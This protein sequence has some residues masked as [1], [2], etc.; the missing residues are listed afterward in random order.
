VPESPQQ[1][2][3]RMLAHSHGKDGLK[4]QAAS[5]AKLSRLIRNVPPAK[6]RKRPAPGKWSV[7]EICA[8]LADTEFAIGFRLRSILGTPGCAISAFN[9][10]A[11]ASAMDYSRRKIRESIEDFRAVR[12]AN[13]DLLN[14]IR[15]EQW[16]DY[17]IH[18]ERGQ[19]TIEHIVNLIA[20]HDLNHIAQIEA[21]LK[22]AKK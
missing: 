17:G 5:A 8:H 4:I 20:G 11:W 12:K 16:K 15:P 7:A 6:L 19:E 18:S 1:Y 13:L 2:I 21:I 9:Q 22:P 3:Q 14:H 10:D